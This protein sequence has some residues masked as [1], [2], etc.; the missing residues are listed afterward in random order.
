M[1]KIT[2]C[3]I[4]I[5]FFNLCYPCAIGSCIE[6]DNSVRGYEKTIFFSTP[7]IY[8]KEKFLELL[9]KDY[10]KKSTGVDSEINL[11]L[12]NKSSDNTYI[13][14]KLE[15]TSPK[16]EYMGFQLTNLKL[17]TTDSGNIIVKDGNR[18]VIPNKVPMSFS[19]SITNE[20]FDYLTS[21]DEFKLLIG[22]M[23]AGFSNF[24]QIKDIQI[25]MKI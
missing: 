21:S 25:Q 23:T 8:V 20:N 1:R 22:N 4:F 17:S 3:L 16:P 13:V 7:I 14:N 19:A 11:I 5:I 2:F 15:C 6:F 9:L 12:D 18:L 24:I 10:I